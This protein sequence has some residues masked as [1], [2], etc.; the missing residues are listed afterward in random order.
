MYKGIA[1]QE[2]VVALGRARMMGYFGTGGLAPTQ[3][4]A[5][6]RAIQN[7]LGRDGAWG[8]NL[9]YNLECPALEGRLVD[10]YHALGVARVEAAGYLRITPSLTRLRLHNIRRTSQ[11]IETPTRI[12]A[13]VSR[14]T[15]AAQFMQPAPEPIVR[16]LVDTRAI[17]PAEA[18]LATRLPIADDICVEADSGGHTDRGIALTL[19]PAILRLRD[20][21]MMRYGYTR[22]IRVGAAGG[23]GTP[24]A[25][26]AAFVM[27]ADFILT[28][29]I[30]QCT[31]EAGTSPAVK[32]VLE[33]LDIHDTV[34]APA[35]DL[36]ETGAQVQVVR[37]GLT[38]A[39]NANILYEIYRRYSSLEEL[40]AR[41]LNTLQNTIFRRNVADVWDEVQAHYLRTNPDRL[42]AI[43]AH[44]RR[45]MAA[46]LRWYFAY[47]STL[48][49][50][51][52]SERP[53]EYQIHCGPALGAFNQWVRGTELQHWHHRHVSDIGRRL[54]HATAA[55]LSGP[56][57]AVASRS[58]GA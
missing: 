40:D 14:A 32:N 55:L 24:E 33:S 10:L 49:L 58:H 17:T 18:D 43:Q 4:E 30:N 46:I 22:P 51:G 19:L 47:T 45:R 54:M 37:K 41:T 34:H 28:G 36:L 15:L 11:G 38:F 27:G 23:I 20:A 48:A 12:L 42:R 31:V 53:S 39:A 3:V 13:K 2:L 7:A 6:L 44:P 26:A 21:T 8:A 52:S 5:S 50:Q 9:L 1:S 29:S 56:Y 16:H 35:G 25:A 57:S